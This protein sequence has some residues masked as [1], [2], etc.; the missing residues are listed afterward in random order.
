MTFR[1]VAPGIAVSDGFKVNIAHP[2]PCWIIL[3]KEGLLE[4]TSGSG[5]ILV[6]SSEEAADACQQANGQPKNSYTVEEFTWDALVDQHG[7]T[8]AHAVI[9]HK[10]APGFYATVPLQ[11][12]I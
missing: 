5:Q 11:K 8:F 10:G 1:Q 7:G 3:S 2:D 6:F 12:G 4:L 9:D